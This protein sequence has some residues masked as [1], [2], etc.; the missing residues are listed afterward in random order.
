MY[1]NAMEFSS[2]RSFHNLALKLP[3]VS[4]SGRPLKNDLAAAGTLAKLWL[5]QMG[6]CT[7]WCGCRLKRA[8]QTP[9]L[10]CVMF[11]WKLP[12]HTICSDKFDG[13]GCTFYIDHGKQINKYITQWM[14]ESQYDQISSVSGSERVIWIHWINSSSIWLTCKMHWFADWPHQ[15]VQK[16]CHG[17][18]FSPCSSVLF[19][20]F[21]SFCC[22]FEI[23]WPPSIFGFGPTKTTTVGACLKIHFLRESGST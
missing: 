1:A 2:S 3:R 4:L 5:V 7:M 19:C 13:L 15:N 12:A 9:L 18:S 10:I 23:C 11:V 17:P 16:K 8:I 20:L 14:L 22:I 6:S 21:V